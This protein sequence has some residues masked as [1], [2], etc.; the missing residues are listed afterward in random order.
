MFEPKVHYRK[1]IAL[2]VQALGDEYDF[3]DSSTHAALDSFFEALNA[4][5]GPM[6]NAPGATLLYA[7]N[8]ML[9]VEMPGPDGSPL[10]R[11][12]R[13]KAEIQSFFEDLTQVLTSVVNV[14]HYRA[15]N[16]RKALVFGIVHGVR[17]EDGQRTD[18][19]S[20]I[21]LEFDESDQVIYEK[22]RV[23][24]R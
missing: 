10:Q 8:A 4:A 19:D 20:R 7:D 13:G 18:L 12:C 23:R 5:M 2:G 6:L 21:E 9:E 1:P 22:V 3:A 15:V 24:R 16:G 14:E 11:H 17:A